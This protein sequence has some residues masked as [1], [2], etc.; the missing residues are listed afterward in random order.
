MKKVS[1]LLI[2]HLVEKGITETF[3][4][5]GGGAMHIDDALAHNPNMHCTFNHHEQA[6]A[7]AGEAYARLKGKLCLVSVTSGPGGTNAIT[8][9]MGAHLDSI[10][11]LV[12]SGQVKRETTIYSSQ[13][14]LRQ[15]GDQ[16]FD[17]VTSV[18]NMTKYAEIVL[19]PKDV[20]YCVDKAIY[21][22]THGRPGPC[23]I[24]IPLDIQSA[25]VEESELRQF[26]PSEVDLGYE[27]YQGKDNEALLTALEKAKR[28][29][30]L[31]GDGIRRADAEEEMITFIEKLGIPV[32]TAW[33]AHDELWDD[34]PLYVG[35]PGTVGTRGGNFATQN[36]DFV[37][38]LGCRLNIRQISYNYQS[39][40]KNAKKAMVDIDNNELHKK[41][42]SIDMPIHADLKDFFASINPY[43]EKRGFK[44]EYE[45]WLAFCRK[46]NAKY[47]ACRKEMLEKD[48]P[49]N[50][51]AFLKK[52]F[53]HLDNDDVIVTGNG[54]ACVQGFQSA[55]V[56][57]GQ[58]L[59]TNSGCAAMGYGFPASI[60]AAVAQKGKRVICLDGDGSFQMNLQEL[61][62]V[63]YNQWNL[64]IVYFNNSG[65]LSIKQTQVNSFKPPLFGCVEGSGLSFPDMEKVAGAYGIPYFSIDSLKECD[66]TL[67]KALAV[68][69]PVFIEAKVDPSQNF[70]PKLGSK[71]L[72]DGTIVS[73]EIDDMSPFLSREEYLEN[74]IPE[75]E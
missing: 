39:W 58:R 13:I 51:Y 22:A 68:E 9:V 72:P 28:P 29:L 71:A 12:I 30:I 24:D 4:V 23:W 59:F 42:I 34:H 19:D 44:G 40:A 67:E 5:T 25:R 66:A 64:K 32:V 20:L 52:M 48:T 3:L 21:L 26:D 74:K 10:P 61:Q 38:V 8:G 31:L 54:A 50:P 62:T 18:K 2:E 27:V 56:K 63:V 70:E 57:K 15:L 53:E 1:D 7:I 49:I 73:P 17:I 46:I 33:N 47:P 69:G 6:C 75:G 41:T 55:I 60:G 35:R 65:Y 43:L 14:P 36:A 37:L 16:E 45:N 11:M